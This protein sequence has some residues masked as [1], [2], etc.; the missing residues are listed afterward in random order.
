MLVCVCV[1]VSVCMHKWVILLYHCHHII[2]LLF[3]LILHMISC[4]FIFIS[5]YIHIFC[6]FVLLLSHSCSPTIWHLFWNRIRCAW[7]SSLLLHS[8]FSFIYYCCWH[9]YRLSCVY[10]LNFVA[11]IIFLLCSCCCCRYNK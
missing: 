8:L 11:D 3:D 4:C 5:C 10:F 6:L 9:R 2:S 7:L 1:R